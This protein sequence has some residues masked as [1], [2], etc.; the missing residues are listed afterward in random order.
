MLATLIA[1]A[2]KKVPASAS[3]A[4]NNFTFRLTSAVPAGNTTNLCLS[5]LSV[6]VC[7]ATLLNGTGGDSKI[8]LQRAL[9]L[10]G[11]LPEVNE[12]MKTLTAAL[13][14]KNEA[15]FTIANSVWL[16]GAYPVSASYQSTLD[17]FYDAEFHTFGKADSE[18]SQRINAWA[19]LHTKQRIKQ[20]VGELSSATRLVLANALTFDGKWEEPFEKNFTRDE[21]FTNG[22]GSKSM[23]PTMVRRGFVKHFIDKDG[24]GALELD[25]RGGRYSMLVLLPPTGQGANQLIKSLSAPRLAAIRGRLENAEVRIYLPKFKVESEYDLNA[26]LARLGMGPLFDHIDLSPINSNF[27]H[28][29][30]I[31]Q[32]VH[33]TYLKLDENGTEAAAATAIV[34]RAGAVPRPNPDEFR[35]DRPFG[36]VLYDRQTSAIVFVG[37]VSKL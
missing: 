2:M 13:A 32:V 37:T 10:R 19:A 34:L 8:V 24:S 15:E 16:K 11:P 23:V 7:F 3:E 26:P 9:G 1:I 5:P 21:K 28:N 17:R 14:A 30:Q 6:G 4:L 36:Y 20:L 12:S 33:K 22:D 27:A 35:A 25:Y 31:S 18:L 29:I